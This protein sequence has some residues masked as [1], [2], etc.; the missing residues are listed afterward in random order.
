MIDDVTPDADDAQESDYPGLVGILFTPRTGLTRFAGARSIEEL[1][2][3]AEQSGESLLNAIRTDNV[4]QLIE[5]LQ[6]KYSHRRVEPG[7]N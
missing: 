1:K 7:Q 4:P 6:R 3:H 2:Q 5:R